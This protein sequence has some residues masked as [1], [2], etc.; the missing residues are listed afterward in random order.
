VA[1]LSGCLT[2]KIAVDDVMIILEGGVRMISNGPSWNV[3]PLGIVHMPRGEIGTITATDEGA[4]T[5]YDTYPR[6]NEAR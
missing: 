4:V 5:A 3:G 1:V 6:W 2:E